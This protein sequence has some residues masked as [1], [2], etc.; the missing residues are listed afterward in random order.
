MDMNTRLSTI[1]QIAITVS[2]V[3]VALKFYR[4]VLG[5][6]FVFRAGPNL[7]FLNAGGIRL[8][9]STQQ[10]AGE[11]GKNSILYFAVSDITSVHSSLVARGATNE[12]APQLTAKMP[13]HELWT[14]F[15]RDPDGNL[16]GLM[17]ERK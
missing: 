3:D 16:V 13:D 7:A 2:D 5:L 17:E 12:R 9:L 6:A 14:G 10:G 4:D 15:L 1:R 8:M 11:V